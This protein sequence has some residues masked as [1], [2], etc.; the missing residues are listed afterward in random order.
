MPGPSTDSVVLSAPVAFHS[1]TTG[2]P[3]YWTWSVPD[4]QD[5]LVAMRKETITGPAGAAV[6]GAGE[7]TLRVGTVCDV[8]VVAC[9]VGS[10]AVPAAARVPVAGLEPRP[11]A[12][13]AWRSRDNA[14]PAITASG[15]LELKE[16]WEILPKEDFTTLG[17]S[18]AVSAIVGYLSIWFLMRFLR[19]HTI[20]IFILYRLGLAGLIIAL[21]SAGV[22]VAQG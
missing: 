7:V 10:E 11:A 3:G 14:I 13:S 16:A 8:C 6:V 22:I 18:V 21:I 12:A 2:W 1:R 20:T 5:G 17:V 4:G 19:T 9:G 15:L